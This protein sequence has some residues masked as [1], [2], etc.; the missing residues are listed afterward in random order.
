MKFTAHQVTNTCRN[1]RLVGYHSA[2]EML[3]KFAEQLEQD[4]RVK[5]E[6]DRK[7]FGQALLEQVQL[8]TTTTMTIGRKDSGRVFEIDS[9][10]IQ[11]NSNG[12]GFGVDLHFRTTG[13]P[14]RVA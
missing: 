9:H 8:D 14:R 11:V 7:D 10:L 3:D 2:A 5:A 13:E 6:A 4:E 12:P 1:L